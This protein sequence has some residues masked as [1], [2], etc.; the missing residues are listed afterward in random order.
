M[1][2]INSANADFNRNANSPPEIADGGGQRPLLGD[3]PEI[4]RKMAADSQRR[5]RVG[6]IHGASGCALA[7]SGC[8]YRPIS[9]NW[10]V[11]RG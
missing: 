9:N 11:P 7:R 4:L 5:L 10:T 1:T 6:P 8:R 3:T 2:P